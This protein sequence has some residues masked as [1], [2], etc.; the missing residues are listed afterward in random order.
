L[1]AWQNL[2]DNEFEKTDQIE[3][4]DSAEN[5]NSKDDLQKNEEK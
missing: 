2:K 5:E 4:E 3:R 1:S